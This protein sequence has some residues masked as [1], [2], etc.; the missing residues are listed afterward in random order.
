[1]LAF[2]DESG[3]PHPDDPTSRP[4]RCLL[5]QQESRNISQSHFEEATQVIADRSDLLFIAVEVE[6]SRLFGY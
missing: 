2:I 3:Q 1:M 6:G 5:P 4:V